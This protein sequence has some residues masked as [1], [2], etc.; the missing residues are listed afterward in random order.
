[1]YRLVELVQ[2]VSRISSMYM[3]M[4]RLVEFVGVGQCRYSHRGHYSENRERASGYIHVAPFGSRF[5][6]TLAESGSISIATGL[7]NIDHLTLHLC[8]CEGEGTRERAQSHS[9]LVY[10]DFPDSARV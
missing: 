8:V 3:Y 7:N 1:M 5:C 6:L 9:E 10:G 2:A 4:Y